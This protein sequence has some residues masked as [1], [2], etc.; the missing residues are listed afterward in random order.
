MIGIILNDVVRDRTSV[1]LA[2]WARLNKDVGHL[3]SSP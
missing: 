3:P 1:W 2:F